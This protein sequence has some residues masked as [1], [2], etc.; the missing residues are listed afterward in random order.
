M[1]ESQEIGEYRKAFAVVDGLML[2][3]DKPYVSTICVVS[4]TIM[5]C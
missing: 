1:N 4:V 5:M 2:Q 3:A